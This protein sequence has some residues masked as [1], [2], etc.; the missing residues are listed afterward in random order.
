MSIIWS[1]TW[2]ELIRKRVVLLTG[3]MTAVFLIAYWFIASTIG[4]EIGQFGLSEN[5]PMYVIERFTRGMMILSLG[6]FFGTFV[7]AF[8]AIFSS[9]SVISGEAE[10]GVLQALMP[11]PLPRWKWYAGR[12]L[13]YVSFGMLYALALF[14]AILGIAAIHAGVPRDVGSLFFAYLLFA[15]VVP[16]LVTVSMLGSTFLSGIG[17]GVLMTM[18]YGGGWLGGMIEKVASQ[19]ASLQP[20]RA[21]DGIGDSLSTISGLLSLAMPADGLQRMML[22]RLFNLSGVQ[23]LIGLRV[24]DL[25]LMLGVGSAPTP[26]FLG[27]AAVYAAVAFAIGILRFQRKDL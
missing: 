10:L 9:S 21:G 7:V 27:Y 8:L 15:S 5:D 18:L 12:W 11:R 25:F 6:F 17:N 19:F 2:K 23:E 26:A 14:A 4:G 3:I 20:G 22:D 13:G 1:M 24:D 16:L